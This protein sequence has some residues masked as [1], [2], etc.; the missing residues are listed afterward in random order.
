MMLDDQLVGRAR[1][2]TRGYILLTGEAPIVR[3]FPQAPEEFGGNN[4]V[5]PA[6]SQ[7]FDDA[8]PRL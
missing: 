3:P 6:E 8:T 4:K 5:G 2:K 7:L 1:R